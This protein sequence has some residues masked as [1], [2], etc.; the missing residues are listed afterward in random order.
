MTSAIG[1][2]MET[3]LRRVASE[4]TAMARQG[5]GRQVVGE[6]PGRSESED[7]EIGVDSRCDAIFDEALAGVGAAVRV[8]SEHG[9]RLV[10]SGQPE[11]LVAVDP[12][13][14]SGLYRR[15]IPAEWWSAASYFDAAGRPLGGGAVDILRGELYL[16][17]A[18]GVSVGPVDGGSRERV[19]P[20]RRTALGDDVTLAA[21]LMQPSYMTEW[22]ARMGRLLTRYP[23]LR[24]W[25]NGGACIYGWLARGRVDAYVMFD[26]PRSEIDPGIGLAV[27]SGTRLFEAGR[28]GALSEY[29]FTPGASAG[30]VRM[31]IASC[32]EDLA[33]EIAWWLA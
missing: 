28:D 27:R 7:V 31:F 8:Y 26:E 22:V 2:A 29:E 16:A 4:V 13:D 25:P 24:V 20:S 18:R 12:F 32:T 3:A 15:G 11:Y 23:G 21:Y 5:E 30:R 10:G 9:Q 17:D 19:E 6:V 14:G 33:A 1:V